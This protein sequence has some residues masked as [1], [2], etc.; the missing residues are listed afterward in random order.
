MHIDRYERWYL[1]GAIALLLV[2]MLALA[3]SSFAWG[4]RVPV[5]YE[6]VDPR[7]VATPP[8]PWGLSEEERVRE[9]A[10]G[11]YEAY[12]LG[13]MWQFTPKLITV[14]KGSTITFY[15]TSKDVQHGLK[16][17]GTNINM[18]VLPGQVSVL[19]ATFD[20]PGTYNFICHEYC[21][22]LHHTMYGQLVVED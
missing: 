2:F 8:S 5:P 14:P 10:P 4:I 9:L 3:V 1:F 18:M 6:Q 7:T 16:L 12:I 22:A 20:T 13:Q 21:G 11:R 17:S 15:L 19:T